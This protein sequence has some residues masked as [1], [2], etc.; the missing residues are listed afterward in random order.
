MGVD[1]ALVVVDGAPL[2]HRVVD[3]L[4]GL[5]GAVVVARGA[6]A[7]VAG[8]GAIEQVGDEPGLDGPLAGIVAGLSACRRDAC[9]V[10][11]VDHVDADVAVLRACASALHD[12]PAT[13]LVVPLDPHGRPQ[14][15][16]AAWRRS[17]L[18]RLRAAAAAHGPAVHRVAAA[19]AV[20]EVAVAG[21]S[22]WAHNAN[23]P[24]DLRA[25]SGGRGDR[26]PGAK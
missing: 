14:W 3:R 13:D 10:V 19:L 6:R 17:A 2:L 15:L 12:D 20:R 21:P 23:R 26:E 1:K 24:E 11:A 9:V 4:A 16:H 22:G 5:G 25:W 18:P 8:L 7:P